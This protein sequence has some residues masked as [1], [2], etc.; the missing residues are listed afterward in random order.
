MI[1]ADIN[2]TDFELCFI[3][4]CMLPV[5]SERLPDVFNEGHSRTVMERVRP[6]QP[7]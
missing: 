2:L 4:S 3:V 1:P 7:V 5:R 6:E